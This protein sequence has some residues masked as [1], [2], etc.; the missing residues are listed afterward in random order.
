M[1]T[2]GDYNSSSVDGVLAASYSQRFYYP[3]VTEF[4]DDT[5]GSDCSAAA[6]IIA[7]KSDSLVCTMYRKRRQLSM[8]PTQQTAESYLSMHRICP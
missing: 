4:I 5:S 8:L 3:G 7:K 6:L 1:P 2:T